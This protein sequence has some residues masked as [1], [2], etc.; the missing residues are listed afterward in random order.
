MIDHLNRF[1]IIKKEDEGTKKASFVKENYDF[2][3]IQMSVL[4][5]E[6]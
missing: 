2:Y 4:E 6:I 1:G 3:I 5:R